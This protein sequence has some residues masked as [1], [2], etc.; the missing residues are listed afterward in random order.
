MFI[1]ATFGDIQVKYVDFAGSG[2]VHLCGGTISFIAAYIMGPRIGRFPPKGIKEEEGVGIQNAEIQ[3][4]SV[5]V[6][7]N[8]KNAN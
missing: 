7:Y 8:R 6:G 3:G 2:M 5:P 4:H 1:G